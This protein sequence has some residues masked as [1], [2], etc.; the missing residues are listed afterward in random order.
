[1]FHVKNMTSEDFPFAIRITNT[2][3]WQMAKEDFEF[4]LK[5]EPLGCF[6]L[7][8]D[9]ERAGIVTTV[10]FD[11]VGWLGN[12]IVAETHR[13]KGAGL[14]LARHAITYLTSK[15]VETIGLYAY[16]DKVPFYRRLGFAYDSEFIVLKG[17]GFSSTVVANL[18]E[19]K[20]EDIQDIINCDKTCFGAS[21]RKL[22]ELILL[23][24]NNSY[25]LCIE[26]GQMLGYAVAKAYQDMA[27]LG[28]LVCR[29]GHSDIAIDLLKAN[30]NKLDRFEVSMCVPKRETPILNML[31]MHGFTEN[32]RVARM[33]YKPQIVKDCIYIAESLERG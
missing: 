22:L 31:M 20:K 26:N 18:R 4:M 30:L 8:Y 25:Y 11:R 12:L 29:Q 5:L 10:S 24:K 32:F 7:F 16:V 17:R 9:S 2:M 15:N 28:P 27:E 14:L 19:A 21:R 6:V 1:M 3:D 33:F 13:E 23:D